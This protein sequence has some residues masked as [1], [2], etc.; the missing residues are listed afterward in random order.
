MNIHFIIKYKNVDWNN[1][2]KIRYGL[3][4]NGSESIKEDFIYNCNF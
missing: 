1:I 4:W 2:Y 3:V